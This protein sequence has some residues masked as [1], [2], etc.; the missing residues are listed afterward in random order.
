[1]I[2]AEKLGGGLN[3]SSKKW[4]IVLYAVLFWFSAW[5]M[6]Q[7]FSYNY[8]EGAMVI[9]FKVISDFSA[10]IPLIRSFS[11][12]DNWPPEY[13]IFPG[14]PIRYHFLFFF[15]VAQLEKL[16]LPIHWAF[17]IPS[18]LGFFAIL[19]MIYALGKRLFNDIRIAL[20]GLAFFVFNGSLAFLQ[21]FEKH[22]LSTSTIKDIVTTL[23]YSAM[24][25]WD[26]GKVLGMWH[27]NVFVNQ[28]HFCVAL[29]LL[30]VFIY[31][32]LRL[33][34]R[35]RKTHLIT[36]AVFG[37]PVG[38]LPLFHQPVMLMF[39]VVMSVFFLALP[40]LR[41]FLLVMGAIS[42]SVVGLLWFYSLIII[43]STDSA[44]FGWHPGFTLHEAKSYVEVLSFFW[45]QFGLH[46]ILAPI[47]LILAPW[48][49]KIIILPALLVFAIA[50]LFQFSPDILANHKF[51]N[52]GLIMAPNAERVR[53]FPNLRFHC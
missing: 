41:L 51:I 22:P 12:G 13:P 11:F 35:S 19:A 25:P 43:G 14:E 42:L 8:Q 34:N 37:I 29:G 20:L 36:A 23:D 1:M 31:A 9:G 16:G 28:R 52:F 26:G 53:A 38:F 3:R 33:E 44:A 17:N 30:M 4:E 18:A 46:C 39:A 15:L 5:I 6:F 50:F 10:N 48:R 47:G 32:C 2:F 49:A 27:L 45:Y 40:Y 21:F 7:T 24:G